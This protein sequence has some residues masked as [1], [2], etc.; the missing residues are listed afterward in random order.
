[1]CNC[2]SAWLYNNMLILF[3]TSIKTFHRHVD[4]EQASSRMN[5]KGDHHLEIMIK[6]KK[7]IQKVLVI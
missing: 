6:E 2:H 7:N 5:V 4:Q 1:M 3:V